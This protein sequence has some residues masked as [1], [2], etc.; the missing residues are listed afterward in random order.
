VFEQKD[1][2]AYS[3]NRAGDNQQSS[4]HRGDFCTGEKP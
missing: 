2:R 4:P 1:Y 3:E